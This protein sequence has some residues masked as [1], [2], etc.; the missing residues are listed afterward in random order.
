MGTSGKE[1]YWILGMYYYL[2]IF[3]N[4]VVRSFWRYIMLYTVTLRCVYFSEMT[5]LQNVDEFWLSAVYGLCPSELI[6]LRDDDVGVRPIE[7]ICL[8]RAGDDADCR[9][10]RTCLQ[11]NVDVCDGVVHARP[12]RGCRFAE[13]DVVFHP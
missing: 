11:S 4:I 2:C 3:G 9:S 5:F 10:E 12:A 8:V 1:K 7:M 13:I 6:S